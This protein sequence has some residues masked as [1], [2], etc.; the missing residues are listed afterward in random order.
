[1]ERQF[2]HKPDNTYQGRYNNIQAQQVRPSYDVNG[3]AIADSLNRLASAFNDYRVS[4]EK[5]KDQM[6]LLEAQRMLNGMTPEDIE[7]LNV[8]DA[9]QTQGYMSSLS[10]PYFKAHADRLRGGFLAATMKQR[11]DNEYSMTPAK[12]ADEEV[13][14]YERYSSEY[15]QKL[16]E[17][18][19]APQNVTAFD[20]GYFESNQ[21]NTNKLAGDWFNKKHAEDLQ[22][23][24]SAIQSELGGIVQSTPE[25]LQTDGALLD[26]TQ[27]VF[28][29]SRLMGLAPNVRQQLLEDYCKQLI[30][31]GHIS[32]DVLQD[33][34]DNVVIQ[35]NMDGT[36]TKASDLLNMQDYMSMA[37]DYN[38]RYMTQE[39]ADTIKKYSDL[40]VTGAE[41]F[42]TEM[43]KIKYSE[44]EKYQRLAPL[45]NTIQSRI[46]QKEAERQRA[47]RAAARGQTSGR[48]TV[49]D[50]DMISDIIDT[51][52]SGGD[53]WNGL[54]LSSVKISGDAL[55]ATAMYR[56]NEAVLNGNST[57]F[58]R[59]L[60]MPQMAQFRTSF[61]SSIK[62]QLADIKLT[63]DGGTTADNSPAIN[64][65]IDVIVNNPNSVERALGGD[66]ATEGKVLRSIISLSPNRSE[67]IRKYA[68]YNSVDEAV[69]ANARNAVSKI[70]EDGYT[71]EGVSHLNTDW[72]N[73]ETDTVYISD[74][75]NGALMNDMKTLATAY[76]VMGYTAVNAVNAAGRDVINKYTTY[77]WGAFPKALYDDLA[78]DDNSRWF[79][80]ALD[81]GIYEAGDSPEWTR[82]TYN[83]T[84]QMFKFHNVDGYTTYELSLDDVR[85]I[86]KAKYAEA[87]ANRSNADTNIDNNYN[88]SAEDINSERMAY[89]QSFA[90][91]LRKGKE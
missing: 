9:A 34:M 15:K 77:H 7:K 32:G 2:N 83:S 70:I 72:G 73:T 29:E 50:T 36:T 25:L 13:A 49:S 26:M 87:V 17:S 63:A 67:G 42:L 46:N 89:K 5:Y 60:E 35:T 4:H 33:V 44:P 43:E 6:G 85:R 11:Y 52:V 22:V 71:V 55:S 58:F 88:G 79:K 28:A 82:I 3:G 23:T 37:N 54:P 19:A 45:Y 75:N 8:I 81:S 80:E 90:D 64:G 51:W 48:G 86:A 78:T 56:M 69:K 57:E 1:M 30:T 59:I 40:G 14:R 47:E 74:M 16:M 20:I 31:S 18:D 27:Q 21:I 38:N 12:S 24:Y 68:E 84:N 76:A 53:M 91:F 62:M 66:V 39:K 10:N 41:Q 61:S 65:L